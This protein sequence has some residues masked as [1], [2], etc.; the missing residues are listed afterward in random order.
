MRFERA[1]EMEDSGG[2]WKKKKG[3]LILGIS[4]KKD[5]QSLEEKINSYDLIENSQLLD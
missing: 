4:P 5:S 1:G 2:D 3:G